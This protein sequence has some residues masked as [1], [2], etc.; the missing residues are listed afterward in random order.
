MQG[1]EGEGDEGNFLQYEER[2]ERRQS[3]R[4]NESIGGTDSEWTCMCVCAVSGLPLSL[5]P[6]PLLSL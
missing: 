3:D 6:P 5:L 4:V 1:R 2:E